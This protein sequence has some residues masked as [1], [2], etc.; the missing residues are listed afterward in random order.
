MMEIKFRVCDYEMTKNKVKQ[1][2]MG[3]CLAYVMFGQGISPNR[4]EDMIEE[5]FKAGYE[6][7]IN[8][9]CE[10]FV[11]KENQD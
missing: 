3:E 11:S 9:Y 2:L 10:P 1:E 4:V 8:N 6:E 7:A 5:S